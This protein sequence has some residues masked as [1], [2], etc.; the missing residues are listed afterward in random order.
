MLDEIIDYV[1]FLRLQVKVPSLSLSL[2]NLLFHLFVFHLS[3]S[4]ILSPLPPY[5][6]IFLGWQ[7]VMKNAILIKISWVVTGEYDKMSCDILYYSFLLFYYRILFKILLLQVLSVS[8]LG[9]AAA[10]APIVPDKSPEV[11]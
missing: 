4:F 8:R 3:L 7:I 11:I 9:G 10:V 5:E 6:R 2:M 1:K